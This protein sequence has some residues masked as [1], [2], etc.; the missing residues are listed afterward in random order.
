MNGELQTGSVLPPRAA[1][2]AG[3]P[4]TFLL[5]TA[6]C[7]LLVGAEALGCP[8][9]YGEAEGTMIDGTRWSVAFLGGLVYTLFLG[10]GGVVFALRKRVERL[11]DPR[12]G[13]RLAA[14]GGG[15]VDGEE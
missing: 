6:A 12:H 10:A 1:A 11:Q 9:C 13:L 5:V 2:G 15:T 14:R 3:A 4:R 8:V 7:S